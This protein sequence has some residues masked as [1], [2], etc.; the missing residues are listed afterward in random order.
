VELET[1]RL[2]LRPLALSD[3]DALYALHHDA[4][5]Q[6]YF[7][8][9]HL[10]D[11]RESLT[12]LEWHV[13]LWELEGYS[14]FAAELRPEGRFAGWLGLNKV[15]DD[16]ELNGQ[17]EIGWFIDRALWGRGLATEGARAALDFGFGPLGLERI[18]ARYRT[19]NVASGRVMQ[20]IGMDYWREVPNNEV[21]G[22]TVTLYEL[23]APA[24]PAG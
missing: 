15:A 8:D 14:F 6:R 13:G 10:Y 21:P 5:M 11:R 22:T 23:S 3:A 19:D 17:T 24:P 9:G 18:I 20:N 1:A 4:D 2:H 12:W 16:P 7:G